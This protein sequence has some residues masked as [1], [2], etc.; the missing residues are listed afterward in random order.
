MKP[1]KLLTLMLIVILLMSW[2]GTLTAGATPRSAGEPLIRRITRRTSVTLPTAGTGVG[3]L[4]AGGVA[5]PE[6]PPN[7]EGGEAAADNSIA[8]QARV[9][10]RAQRN[11]SYSR[12]PD[13]QALA[14]GLGLM[15]RQA[16]TEP[17]IPTVSPKPVSKS[18]PGLGKSFN[19]L[20]LRDQR[21]ANNGNQ[22]TLE[23]PDQGLCVGNGYIL[24][25]VNTVLRVYDKN[26][27]P[28][29]GVIDHN[30]FYGYPPQI[31]RSDPPVFGPSPG[32]PSCY[33]D[34]D[35]Q[36]WYH[37]TWTL[38]V[39]P[40]TGDLLGPNHFD[41]AISDT[42]SPLGSWTI[43]SLPVQNDGTDGTPTHT[44]CPCFGD[45]PHIGADKNGFYITSNEYPFV[46]PGDLGNNFN[47]AQLYAFSKK[48]LTSGADSISVLVFENIKTQA[49]DIGFTVWPAQS[50]AGQYAS[51]A[52]GTEYFLSSLAAEEALNTAG[53]DNR[54]VLWALTNTKSL[55]TSS[56]EPRL[57]SVV[58][59]SESYGIP[60]LSEQKVGSVPLRDCLLVICLPGIGDG[61]YSGEVEGP[62]DS[63][64][65]R[66]QQVWYVNGQLWSA[67]D[68]IANAGGN[69]KAGIAYFVVR[70]RVNSDGVVSGRI[71]KQGYLAAPDNNVI[72]PA[73]AVLPSG[74]GVMAFTLV[75]KDYYPSAAYTTIDGDD[76][77]NIYIA[78]AG[79]GPQDG[80]CE[81]K[82]FN[83]GG[84]DPTPTARPRWGDYGAAVT[85]GDSIWIGSEFI[86]QT[87]T[88]A[89]YQKDPGCGGTR[90]TLG[91][92]ATRISVVK[93]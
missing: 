92:W 73:I 15:D 64:D 7:V 21:L 43:Y 69:F 70:P 87:C 81:Y 90:V 53:L 37:L 91:N 1:R 6:F 14:Q 29:T 58:L 51:S 28:L 31:L 71:R 86:A 75:G 11:R 93:P 44:D 65:S 52:G 57:S 72:Y 20:N 49:G 41:L 39:D 78:G 68:T 4:P 36:R 74:K 33:Y 84:T 88:F 30:T 76:V 83:C 89:E 85:D 63:N 40:A 17:S 82:F 50:S 55:G 19:G 26:G 3:N 56:P 46:G 18:K 47:G 22:F 25:T 61:P 80:V 67:L 45:Y 59:A 42:S 8:A 12:R 32:D 5:L 60:P 24:E 16:A 10:A 48:E 13:P 38:D 27:K 35:N 23:P 66:I 34:P 62:L 79:R 9:R 77:G 2:L 54:L